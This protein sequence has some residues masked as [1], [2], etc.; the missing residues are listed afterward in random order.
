[1]MAPRRPTLDTLEQAISELSLLREIV[2]DKLIK[3]DE[4]PAYAEGAEDV[5]SEVDDILDRMRAGGD[6]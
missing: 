3:V 6:K 4:D 5:L 2:R 1:M